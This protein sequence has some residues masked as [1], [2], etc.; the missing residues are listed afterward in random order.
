MQA[1]RGPGAIRA[2]YQGRRHCPWP[3]GL[4]DG[5]PEPLPAD[6]IVARAEWLTAARPRTLRRMCVSCSSP[7]TAWI[8]P[9]EWTARPPR[10]TAPTARRRNGCRPT[11]GLQRLV[12]PGA[13]A[14]RRLASSTALMHW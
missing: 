3:L 10:T 2:R 12:V 7:S 6:E 5:G 1:P 8:G 9:G 11:P 13:E 4:G 14:N